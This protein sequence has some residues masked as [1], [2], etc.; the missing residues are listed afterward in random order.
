MA[1]TNGSISAAELKA[2]ILGI[3]DGA[4]RP[5]R[6]VPMPE[7][8]FPVYIR[9]MTGDQRD[10]LEAWQIENRDE[11]RP[12]PAGF[13][14]KT[15][16]MSLCGSDGELC[17]FDAAD[18]MALG[19]RSGKA[20]ERIVTAALDESGFSKEDVAELEKNSGSEASADSGSNSA[21]HTA[22]R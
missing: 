10:E 4:D 12:N 11:G 8:G 1:E 22:S 17:D 18:V 7:W 9:G 6:K 15:V 13:R 21:S 3:P 19:A 16:A 2:K 5:V 14:A 20:L